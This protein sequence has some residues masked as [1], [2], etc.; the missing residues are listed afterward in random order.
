MSRTE[1]IS[2]MNFIARTLSIALHP[3]LMPVYVLFFL[4]SSNTF[5]SFLPGVTKLYCYVVTVGLLL[6]IP[7]ASLPLFK[8][9]HLIRNYE[10]EDKQERIYPILVT[11]FCA[12][13]GF[14]LLGFVAYTVIV[15]QLYLTLVV[16][17]SL[18]FIITLYWKMSMH[19]TAIGGVCG[20]LITIALKYAGDVRGDFM[21]M[22]VLAG[23]LAASRLYLKKHTP[24]QV[25]AG[26]LFGLCF[27]VAIQLYSTL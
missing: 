19:M 16:L 3:L 4:F 15:Q 8:F 22:L 25:Y 6:L 2:I 14:W 12:F 21:L 13:L 7:L 24:L 26:F 1:S 17:L 5:F 10:L 23:L 11:V 20:F 18:F 9:F 27:V